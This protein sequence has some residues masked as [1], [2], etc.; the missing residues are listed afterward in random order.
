[1]TSLPLRVDVLV[2]WDSPAVNDISNTR[3]N[4][5]TTDNVHYQNA[6]QLV[7][8]LTESGVQFELQVLP[9]YSQCNLLYT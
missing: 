7:K 8:I 2:I 5:L 1:M 4:S 6:A 3:T 9:T